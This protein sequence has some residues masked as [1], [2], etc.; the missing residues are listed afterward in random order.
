MRR[1]TVSRPP[2][3]ATLHGASGRWVTWSAVLV[4]LWLGSVW[5]ADAAGQTVNVNGST[6]HGP[7]ALVA[8]PLGGDLPAV[9]RAR[10]VQLDPRIRFIQGLTEG[11]T[12]TL[13][14]F[15][16]SVYTARIDRIGKNVNGT[17]TARA[18]ISGL[19]LACAL[20]SSTDG[21]TLISVDIPERRQQFLVFSEPDAGM[22]QVL[23]LDPSRPGLLEDAPC[24]TPPVSG[25]AYAGEPPTALDPP[26]PFDPARVD[27]MVVYTPAASQWASGSGGIANVIANAMQRAQL[28]LDNSDTALT[29]NLVYSA[30][31]SYTESGNSQTDLNR[32][33][34]TGDGYMDQVH[35][36]RDQYGADLVA[37]FAK[38]EDTGGISWVLRSPSGEPMYG[39]SLTRVQQ[40][41]WT[42]THIHEMGHNM[43]CH[44]RKD[45]SVQPGPGL[46]S[47][48]AGWRWIG[49]DS[50]LYC[51]V[52]SYEDGGYTRVAYFSNPSILY[53]GVP[54]GDAV[55]G[56]NARTLREIKHVI[57]GYRSTSHSPPATPTPVSPINGAIVGSLTPALVATVFS[58]PDGDSHVNSHWQVD[59]DGA[60][61]SPE[62]DSGDTYP[63]GTQTEVPS[64]L[65]AYGTTYYWRV[66]YRDGY[67]DWSSWSASGSFTVVSLAEALDKPQLSWAT[68]GSAGWFGQGAV[69][70]DGVDAGQSGDVADSQ[71]SWVQA[72][73]SGPATLKF[74]WKVSSEAGWDYL[75]FYVD[76]LLKDRITGEVN[77]QEK[78]YPI[79]S[80]P[81]TIQW[82]YIKDSII[83]AGSDCGWVDE[84]KVCLTGDIN[85]DGI[86]DATDLLILAGTFGNKS[87]DPGYD[88]R[89]DLNGDSKVDVSDILVL[90]RNWGA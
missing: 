3:D 84:V 29:V 85:L 81:H 34:S 59:D 25:P 52:M 46:F 7:S 16:D 57:A 62:W 76:G 50:G 33:T 82:R 71:E 35:T 69:S 44:H 4:C 49:N 63:A 10:R 27:V 73:I 1:Q 68:G 31:V 8:V 9:R 5:P 60:F 54:T 72:Q 41:S 78:S 75:E 42:Y 77:W 37:L 79:A 51:S 11:E 23:D 32:L 13:N 39:F 38:V 47:Y 40:A 90:G 56:D 20:M 6:T 65:L 89:A 21:Q 2:E 36:W 67:G 55:D 87:G 58:D 15:E 48:S 83:S 53:Q 88:S 43:G 70:H 24:L 28:A 80:G 45:Q 30:E 64:D 61:A 26:G 22:H 19:P 17:L 66:R 86:V 12:I 14:L 18:R 74:W